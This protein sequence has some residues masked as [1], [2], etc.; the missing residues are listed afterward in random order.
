MNGPNEFPPEPREKESLELDA[1]LEKL[2][3]E[4]RQLR[5]RLP[6]PQLQ[7][8]IAEALQVEGV[9]PQTTA[10]VPRTDLLAPMAAPAPSSDFHTDAPRT[11]PV[12]WE[13]ALIRKTPSAIG[14]KKAKPPVGW[15]AVGPVSWTVIALACCAV[16]LV[17]LWA[18]V[19]WVRVPA[20]EGQPLVS[21]KPS[22]KEAGVPGG[23]GP[24]AQGVQVHPV[25]PA[26][27][28]VVGPYQVR[29]QQGSLWVVA[30]AD[31]WPEPFRVETPAGE[32]RLL[33]TEQRQTPPSRHPLPSMT[34]T[35]SGVAQTG[36][37]KKPLARQSNGR[38]NADIQFIV[39]VL[40]VVA[41]LSQS[42]S[43]IAEQF[44]LSSFK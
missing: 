4:L 19:N 11:W 7:R 10:E 3:A 44:P 38:P 14:T 9:S 12:S 25:G 1:S 29:L 23:S 37:E 36:S 42:G 34:L 18:L 40:P 41:G 2:E 35:T 6:S 16:G 39:E 20:P 27:Y 32:V 13:T 8:R 21:Q 43:A 30:T 5:P 26:Q 28:Q 15:K 17:G 24:L 33:P 31:H 22:K